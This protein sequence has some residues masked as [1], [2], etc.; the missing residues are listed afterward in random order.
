MLEL[1]AGYWMLDA[2]S[3]GFEI[4]I[5]RFNVEIYLVLGLRHC[6]CDCEQREAGSTKQLVLNLINGQL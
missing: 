4:L 5:S 2:G 6:D 1:D 3:S